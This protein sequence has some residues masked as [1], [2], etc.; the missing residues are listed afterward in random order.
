MKN[1]ANLFCLNIPVKVASVMSIKKIILKFRKY[2]SGKKIHFTSLK[3][4][5]KIYVGLH[6]ILLF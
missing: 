3:L 5:Q 6:K 2:S 1:C 4:K